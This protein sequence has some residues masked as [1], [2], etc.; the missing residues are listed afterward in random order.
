[1][2]DLVVKTIYPWQ[3]DCLTKKICPWSFSLWDLL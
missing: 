2:N 1:L 3:V